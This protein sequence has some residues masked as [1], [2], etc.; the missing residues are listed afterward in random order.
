MRVKSNIKNILLALIFILVIIGIILDFKLNN[1]YDK[2]LTVDQPVEETTVITT[3]EEKNLQEQLEE[4]ERDKRK[5]QQEIAALAAKYTG[6]PVAPSA[7]GYTSPLP[8]RTKSAITTGYGAYAGHTGVDFACSGVTPVL[9][10]KDGTVVT[11]TALKYSNGNYKS[12][13]EYIVINHNDGTMTLYAHMQPGSR[14]VGAGAYVSQGQQIGRVGTTGN[15][16]GN[17]L[18]F[19][20]WSGGRRVNPVPYLP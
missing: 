14:M 6:T 13:G 16:T 1:R 17:H 12:Y 5:V 19:E 8:G 7:A 15:S 3:E 4:F 10:V 11:S 2:L 20:V 9:A 18:H